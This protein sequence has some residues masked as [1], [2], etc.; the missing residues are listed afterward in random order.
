MIAVVI[1][2]VQ[3]FGGVI[4]N[5]KE[6]SLNY[7]LAWTLET[8]CYCAVDVYVIITGYVYAGKKASLSKLVSLWGTVLLYSTTIPLVLSLLVGNK[9]S[10]FSL[11]CNLF[12]VVF[13]RYW[14][15]NAYFALFLFIPSCNWIVNNKRLLERTL[16]VSF[17]LF[18]I[19]SLFSV[20]ND[21]F[22]TNGGSSV[23]WFL[24]LYLC[25]AY[26]KVYGWPS[27][28]TIKKSIILY[29]LFIVIM[30]LAK[31]IILWIIYSVIG[32][33]YSWAFYSYTSPLI[34]GE[35]ICLVSVFSRIRINEGVLKKAISLI[36]PLTFGVYLIHE[37]PEF[38]ETVMH[39][40]FLTTINEPPII[41]LSH[42][43]GG[44]FVI[45][46]G[47]LVVEWF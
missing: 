31:N 43:M 7:E 22:N 3:V 11:I 28:L 33:Y 2:H 16:A 21:L 44:A 40:R 41:M 42:I 20:N 24:N 6:F 39:D 4:N 19:I 32:K 37:N 17:I 46:V 30:M 18:S 14:F 13:R 9:L 38:R 35:A 12:P 27:W 47:A 36:S 8:I 29:C 10:V 25:G 15:F 23:I 45:F 1:L 26:F 5:V 34:Y